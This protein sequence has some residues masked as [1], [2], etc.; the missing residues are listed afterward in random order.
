MIFD[1]EKEIKYPKS[2]V[3]YREKCFAKL[4]QAFKDSGLYS[5]MEG[6]TKRLSVSTDILNFELTRRKTIT[7][8]L[9]DMTHPHEFRIKS[10]VQHENKIILEVEVNLMYRVLIEY[11]DWY[12]NKLIEQLDKLDINYTA[13]PIQWDGDNINGSKNF[14]ISIIVDFSKEIS[15]EEMKKIVEEYNTMNK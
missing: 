6:S 1:I 3:E 5:Y 9:L 12:V 13:S 8:D 7:P 15:D 14:H 10:D 2:M 11:T 4:K